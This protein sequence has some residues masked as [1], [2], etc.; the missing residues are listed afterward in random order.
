[1]QEKVK[2]DVALKE[3]LKKFGSRGQRGLIPAK[4]VTMLMHEPPK[5]NQAYGINLF[6]N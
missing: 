4:K 5:R 3:L 1:M 6:N 2:L